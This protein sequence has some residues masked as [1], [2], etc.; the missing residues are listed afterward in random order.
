MKFVIVDTK[1]AK[2]GFSLIEVA[3]AIVVIGLVVGLSLKG[4][5][6]IHTAKLNSIVDQV[7]AFRMAAQ[8]FTD[9]YSAIPGDFNNAK[10]MIDSSLENGAGISSIT[11]V[12]DAKRFWKHLV[13]SGLLSVELINGFPVS[14]IG[15]YFSVST[16]VGGYEGTWVILSKGTSNN[17]SF[18][19]IIS[20]E[21]AY[22]I[23]KKYDNGVPSSGEI[24]TLRVSGSNL[25]SI[26]QKYDLK[27]KKSDCIIMFR[28]W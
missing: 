16:N 13:A 19:G 6:L 20:Q 27:S 22:I 5:E 12:S 14:K 9:K 15:G 28:L 26:G 24:R 4:K 11:S 18:S 10:E 25:V 1:N 17:T 8:M 3:I 21:D 7:N 23:D 2:K